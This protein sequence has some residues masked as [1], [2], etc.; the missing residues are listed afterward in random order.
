[1]TKGDAANLTVNHHIIHKVETCTEVLE[2]RKNL[3]QIQAFKKLAHE[4][5]IWCRKYEKL[6]IVYNTNYPTPQ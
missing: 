6:I 1:M 5:D 4:T 3:N 2:E